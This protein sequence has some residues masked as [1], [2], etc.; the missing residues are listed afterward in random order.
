ML[1]NALHQQKLGNLKNKLQTAQ[2]LR[3]Q[4]QSAKQSRDSSPAHIASADALRSNSSEETV[5]AV[6]FHTVSDQASGA[7]TQVA[8]A[9]A[10]VK[11]AC[12]EGEPLK[13]AIALT[14]LVLSSAMNSSVP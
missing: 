3:Q 7:L 1:W 4:L 9:D 2:A 11:Q 14:K 6:P 10:L 8:A 12:P 5:L 13:H